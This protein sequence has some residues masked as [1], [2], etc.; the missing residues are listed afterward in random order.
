MFGGTA[1]SKFKHQY[2][3]AVSEVSDFN[4]SSSAVGELQ[5][6]GLH[7]LRLLSSRPLVLAIAI[8]LS[9][10]GS[11]AWLVWAAIG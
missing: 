2:V 10:W 5:H 6:L 9:M 1:M 11:L 3:S 4:R 8:S 7:F